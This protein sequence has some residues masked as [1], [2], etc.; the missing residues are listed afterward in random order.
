MK[1]YIFLSLAMC[2]MICCTSVDTPLEEDGFGLM[3]T[4]RSLPLVSDSATLSV[5]GCCDYYPNTPVRIS[6]NAVGATQLILIDD[7]HERIIPVGS[8][9]T[10]SAYV[11]DRV[12]L[13]DKDGLMLQGKDIEKC[14]IRRYQV[15]G[16]RIYYLQAGNYTVHKMM[17]WN[18]DL[19]WALKVKA[20]RTTGQNDFIGKGTFAVIWTAPN[21]T[22]R[23]FDMV[24]IY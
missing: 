17:G 23:S 15:K 20:S 10:Y 9:G 14:C 11:I 7:K 21:G 1:L 12:E 6:W 19:R 24:R 5:S 8:T 16:D 4:E 22:Y 18:T 3:T 2:A 13:R